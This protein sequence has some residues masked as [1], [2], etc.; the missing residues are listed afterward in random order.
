MKPIN[1]FLSGI[2]VIW[3]IIFSIIFMFSAINDWSKTKKEVDLAS[4]MATAFILSANDAT[5]ATIHIPDS[6]LTAGLTSAMNLSTDVIKCALIDITTYNQ[7]TD[8]VLAD[9][10]QVSGTGYTAGGQTVTSIVTAAD[11][12]NH[13]TTIVITPAV[14]TGSTTIS[15]TGAA[16]YDSTDGNRLIAIDDFS[17]TVS[18]SGGTYTVAAITLKFT[19]F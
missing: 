18:S 7:A 16:C 4:S 19:H 3:A 6:F 2:A 8:T 1:K 14:W 9:V 17:G 15:A 5:A 13:W 11:T 12:T 10:T